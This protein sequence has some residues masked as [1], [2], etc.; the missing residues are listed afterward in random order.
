MQPDAHEETVEQVQE[1]QA[2]IEARDPTVVPVLVDRV[3]RTRDRLM[4][5]LLI[6]V[7]SELALRKHLRQLSKLYHK[8]D[9]R[10]R[11]WVLAAIARLEDHEYFPLLLHGYF[12]DSS[13]RIRSACRRT[14][15]RL[16]QDQLGRLIESMDGHPAPWM[17]EVATLARLQLLKGPMPEVPHEAGTCTQELVIEALQGAD[18]GPMEGQSFDGPE[19]PESSFDAR[20]SAFPDGPPAFGEVLVVSS[21]FGPEDDLE[22]SEIAE[23]NP[24]LGVVGAIPGPA[25]DKP[26]RP[27]GIVEAIAMQDKGDQ[28]RTFSRKYCPHCHEKIMVVALLCR[29]CG[30]VF[31]PEGLEAVMEASRVQVIPLPVRSPS[32][33]GSALVLDLVVSLLLLPVGGLGLVYLLGK[34]A[35]P[36]GVSLGKRAYN[37]KVVHSQ[38]GAPCT[39]RESLRRNLPLLVPLL[40]MIEVVLLSAT[41]LRLGDRAAETRVVFRDDPPATALLASVSLTM[42]SVASLIL[43]VVF[44]LADLARGH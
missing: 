40:P 31:D 32:H 22:E 25:R 30:R 33:R 19:E 7:A 16:S 21:A 23:A 11:L 38:T 2:R 10:V 13:K 36:G 4:A 14:L 43:V 3:K 28:D 41:G 27:L 17:Q 42:L 34:D 12:F 26:A 6:R 29:Y 8:K 37:L 18:L 24:S 1:L 39:P 44:H 35:L 20:G 9:S 5:R 15:K